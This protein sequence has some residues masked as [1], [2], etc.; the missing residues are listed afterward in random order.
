MH[1]ILI[2]QKSLNLFW[3]F[4]I[5][6]CWLAGIES[7]LSSSAIETMR[8]FW[9]EESCSF[10]FSSYALLALNLSLSKWTIE[11]GLF[12]LISSISGRK[13]GSNYFLISLSQL[14]SANQGWFTISSASLFD[15]K[16]V[17]WF[18]SRSL[19]IISL[20]LSLIGIP[21]LIGSGY[22]ML[23]CLICYPSLWWFWF[24]K[25]GLPVTISYINI[26]KVH[27][28]TLNPWPF[29]SR[30]SG[31]KYSAVPQKDLVV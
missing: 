3:F 24:M 29:M 14:I 22:I 15:P 7:F 17:A 12:F 11:S 25:G 6:F 19:L 21:C 13:G 20:R 1:N 2:S 16:R 30:I 31:A 8:S 23:D 10:E 26:P 4:S 27:Q 18:L 28:S 9:I 5:S